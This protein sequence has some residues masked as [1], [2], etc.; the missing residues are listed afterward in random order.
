LVNYIGY[1]T[2][3]G[4][5]SEYGIGALYYSIENTRDHLI[6]KNSLIEETYIK[7]LIPFIKSE[8]LILKYDLCINFI[9][10]L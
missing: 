8:G 10:I 9:Y 2:K 7:D 6:I 4:K 1:F 3:I 5:E